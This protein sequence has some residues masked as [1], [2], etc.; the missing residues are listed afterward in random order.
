MPFLY[1]KGYNKT[2]KGLAEQASMATTP[3]ISEV[4]LS[5]DQDSSKIR[6]Y[7]LLAQVLYLKPLAFENPQKQI[8]NSAELQLLANHP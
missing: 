5:M 6:E 2:K 7:E 8:N 3:E 1:T 4:L